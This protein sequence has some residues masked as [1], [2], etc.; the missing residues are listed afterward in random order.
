MAGTKN[1]LFF[2]F[3]GILCYFPIFLH[4]DTE[5]LFHWDEARN[6]LNAL[7]MDQN[8][9]PLVRYYQG[10]PE[11]WETKPPLLIWLQV[12]LFKIVG[13]NE[14][15][16]RLPSALAA[17]FTLI[18]IFRFF[19]KELEDPLGGFF[20]G[21]TLV[22][23]AGYIDFHVVR[24]GD[25]DALLTLFQTALVIYGYKYLVTNPFENR[26]LKVLTITLILSILTKSI[27]GFA[28]L[29]GIFIYAIFKKQTLKLFRQKELWIAIATI[30]LTI[31]GYYFLREQLQP[32]YLQLVW[33]NELFPR[34]FNNA[35]SQNY[36]VPNS[37]WYYLKLIAEKQFVYFAYLLP[38]L[39]TL[40]FLSKNQ[41]AR[42]FAFYLV[43]CASVFL[44]L[45]SGG[46]INSWYDAPVFPLL[47]MLAGIG[48]STMLKA[49][50][51]NLSIE[52]TWKKA[53]LTLIF[54]ATF[55]SYPYAKI[56]EKVYKPNTNADRYGKFMKQLEQQKMLPKDAFV[57]YSWRN[58]SFLF[59]EK[60]YNEIKGWEIQSCGV[61]GNFSNCASLPSIGQ[62][63]I[64]C[65]SEFIDEFEKSYQFT[66]LSQ[67]ENCRFY[68]IDGIKAI[69]PKND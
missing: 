25:H 60:I 18:L 39:L 40:V 17:V 35:E 14:L 67:M 69:Q 27:M 62:K 36:R 49:F 57:F 55:F 7:E 5:S 3:F 48:F 46:T 20:A 66:L 51:H 33:E 61:R 44:F 37:R 23:S 64:I 13:Y 10:A 56:I 65:R 34:Y 22:C 12:V 6:G 28:M 53:L 1:I 11:T 50:H 30:I 9:K 29:P 59:Y 58:S 54:T 15:A 52:T 42:S 26:Y 19:I 38:F 68:T 43:V 24:T 8:G 31:G 21:L 45:I 32:G 4:L 41:K 2:I 16:I 47:A 63:V